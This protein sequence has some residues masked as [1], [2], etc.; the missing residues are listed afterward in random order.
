M[1]ILVG[2]IILILICLILVIFESWRENRKVKVVHYQ[3]PDF[4]LKNWVGTKIM[5]LTDLHNCVY[6]RENETLLSL[7]RKQSPDLIL[8]AGDML[9]G[10][11]K[12]EF[13]EAVHFLNR[14]AELKIPI[15]YAHGNHELRLKL[16]PEQYGD[17]YERFRKEL[18]PDINFLLNES[19]TLD[20]NG[21]K[22]K[23]FGLDL[24][25]K[26]YQRFKKTPMEENYLTD[27]WE[28][29]RIINE[30]K[31]KNKTQNEQK[32][33]DTTKN[34][35]NQKNKTQNEQN[36]MD[37]IQNEQNQMDTTS[38]N[39][40]IEL[41]QKAKNIKHSNKNIKEKKI[42]QILIAHNPL[43][44]EEYS[45]FGVDMV[46]SGHYHGCM[47]RIPVL[48]GILSPQ[49]GFFPKYVAGEYREKNSVLYLSAGLG[50][51]SIKLRIGNIPE[52]VVITL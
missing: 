4:P 28:K 36:Q 37:T 27:L 7:V 33:I 9:V 23:I 39:T 12:K 47:V 6:G 38:N 26:Y 42:F 44:F 24:D 50:N 25:K 8:I 15:Y 52:I 22:L 35:Q 5:L 2:M 20:K 14:L 45:D 46:V 41:N 31:Q 43:Y 16:Y 21:E 32:Q 29:D 30:Q 13:K 3:Y 40:K 49:I 18:S 1:K 19:V 17:M 34:K 10:K 51:H 11:P 48:G